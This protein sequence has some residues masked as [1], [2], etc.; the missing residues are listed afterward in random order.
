MS[1]LADRIAQA[2]HRNTITQVRSDIEGRR[3]HAVALN[4]IMLRNKNAAPDHRVRDDSLD[5]VLQAKGEGGVT[6]MP[7]PSPD[8]VSDDPDD[9]SWGRPKLPKFITKFRDHQITAVNEVLTHF[10]NGHRVV[11]MQAPTGAGKTIMAE[12]IRRRVGG[13]AVYTC[14]TRTLQDQFQ[15]DFPY[16][17]VLKGRS[18]YPTASGKRDAFGDATEGAWHEPTGADCTKTARAECRWCPTMGVCPYRIAKREALGSDLTVLNTAYL[19]TEL[20]KG[21]AAFGGRDLVILDEADL[22][23]GQ[24]MGQVEVTITPKWRKLLKL[25]PPVRKTVPSAWLSWILETALPQ[26]KTFLRTMPPVERATTSGIRD[27]ATLESLIEDLEA[28]AGSMATDQNTGEGKG[29]V[30][31]DYSKD[32]SYHPITF[33]PVRVDGY[34]TQLWGAGKLMLLMSGTILSADAMAKS[35][36]LDEPYGVVDVPMQFPVENRPIHI[37]PVG[38]MARKAQD[39]TK[40]K[41]VDAIVA[42]INA[43]PNERVLIHTVS[44]ALSKFFVEELRVHTLGRQ[45]VSYNSAWEKDAA[46]ARY[47]DTPGSVMVA[48]SMDRGVD[49]PGDDCRVQIV[50]KIPFGNLGDKQVIA[51]MHSQGGEE[52]YAINSLRSLMQMTGRGVR[53]MDDYCETYILDA[54]FDNLWRSV[55]NF[56]PEWWVDAMDRKMNARYWQKLFFQQEQARNKPAEGLF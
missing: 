15:T 36:G 52:W 29:W 31:T 14:S 21:A 40:P 20:N 1:D 43:H 35:L 5:R 49:L 56:T 6:D 37:A 55:K 53:S 50:A 27:R 25:E 2:K 19:L 8:G 42:I 30:Y 54:G 17:K 7:M 3:L 12:M 23:E 24:L 51:R 44:Y 26:A 46:L 11:F 10:A 39:A 22:L 48:T 38:S 13:Q 45:V 16:A 18:N 47:L 41:M 4:K 34:G 33:K 32:P 9:V 28:V